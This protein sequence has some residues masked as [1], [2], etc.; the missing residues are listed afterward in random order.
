MNKCLLEIYYDPN[1]TNC[2][3]ILDKISPIAG[4][5]AVRLVQNEE[6]VMKISSETNADNT[7]KK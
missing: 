6:R 1:V 3:T 7:I 5:Y 2:T 4:I